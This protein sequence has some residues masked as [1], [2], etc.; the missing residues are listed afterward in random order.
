MQCRCSCSRVND[1]F[2][3]RFAIGL[4]IVVQPILGVFQHQLMFD[5]SRLFIIDSLSSHIFFETRDDLFTFANV[6]RQFAFI[7]T[8]I[9]DRTARKQISKF[10]RSPQD[11]F[12]YFLLDDVD[13][14]T[15]CCGVQRRPSFVVLTIDIG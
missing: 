1:G 6:D 9:D 2:S 15:G 10:A 12:V 7:V 3:E 5:V 14:S 13:V 8:N 4:L 11:S